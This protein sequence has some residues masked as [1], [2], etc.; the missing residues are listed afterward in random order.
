MNE[1]SF[2]AFKAAVAAACAG[3]GATFGWQGWLVAV[4]VVCMLTDYISGTAV[5]CKGGC[6]SSAA[7]RS[8]LWH[9]AGMIFAVAVAGM[10]DCVIGIV[11]ENLPV[12]SLP[13]PWNCLLFP[14]TLCWYILT[15]LGSILENAQQL[16]AP[17]PGFLVKALAVAGES[18]ENAES[19]E[20]E[21]V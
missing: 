7:A 15:E 19:D 4:W 3:F 11:L 17:L 16:G 1:N 8:G 9:K 18:L 2:S 13:G 20:H 12:V 5:A 10:A 14:L 21:T 6:W